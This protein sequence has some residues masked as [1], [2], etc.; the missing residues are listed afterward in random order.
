MYKKTS[1]IIAESTRKHSRK[2]LKSGQK[3]MWLYFFP[4]FSAISKLLLHYYNA[5]G[6]FNILNI[7]RYIPI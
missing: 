5:D 2:A 1:Q 3:I 7:F 6:K 4:F